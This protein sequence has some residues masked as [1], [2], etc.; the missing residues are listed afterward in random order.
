ME[1]IAIIAPL[2]WSLCFHSCSSTDHSTHAFRLILFQQKR[3]S[4]TVLLKNSRASHRTWSRRHSPASGLMCILPTPFSSLTLF[5]ASPPYCPLL[6]VT[7][8]CKVHSSMKSLYQA[9]SSGYFLC[10]VRSSPMWL[11]P[12]LL[13]LGF[14][15][16]IGPLLHQFFTTWV[17]QQVSYPPAVLSFLFPALSSQRL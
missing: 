16:S 14:H 5:P 15:S 11:T 4:V 8:T 6:T 1:V 7:Q 10:R 3:D 12:L 17:T 9:F 13:A 2:C